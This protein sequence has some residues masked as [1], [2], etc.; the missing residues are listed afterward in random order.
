MRDGEAGDHECD[1]ARGG[2]IGCDKSADSL[3]LV[4]TGPQRQVAAETG[5]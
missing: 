4:D 1:N 3:Q 2:R 5:H